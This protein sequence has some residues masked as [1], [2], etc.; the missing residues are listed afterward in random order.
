[1]GTVYHVVSTKDGW[2]SVPLRIRMSSGQDTIRTQTIH[3]TGLFA[4]QLG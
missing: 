2:G 4:D 3:G 1:M